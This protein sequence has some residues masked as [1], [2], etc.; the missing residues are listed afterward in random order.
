[1]TPLVRNTMTAVVHADLRWLKRRRA[2]RYEWLT[3]VGV[4]LSPQ[5]RETRTEL[6]R[7]WLHRDEQRATQRLGWYQAQPQEEQCHEL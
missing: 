5:E 2:T 3:P 4:R 1:M 7:A 6:R